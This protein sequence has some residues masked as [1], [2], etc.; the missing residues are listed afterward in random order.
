MLRLLAVCTVFCLL[1]G[2][3]SNPDAPK[4]LVPTQEQF[5]KAKKDGIGPR[6]TGRETEDGTSK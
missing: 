1:V 6:Q 2:C 4:P 5:D 3:G